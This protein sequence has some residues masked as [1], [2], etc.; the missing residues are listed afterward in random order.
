[1]IESYKLATGKYETGIATVL[2]FE[3]EA[4]GPVTR[5]HKNKLRKNRCETRLRQNFFAERIINTW[6]SLP[7]FIVE[8]PSVFAFERRLDKYWKNQEVKFKY[9]AVLSLAP[10]TNQQVQQLIQ[11]LDKQA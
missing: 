9:E 3:E 7:S 6:N 5:G 4:A 8:S 1:M 10:H 11:D 2:Q